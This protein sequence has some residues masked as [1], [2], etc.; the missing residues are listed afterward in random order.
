MANLL[1]FARENWILGLLIAG[2]FLYI[3]FL[4]AKPTPGIDSLQSLQASVGAGQP[5]VLDFYSNF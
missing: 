5:V 1:Q 3:F 2:V 4:R